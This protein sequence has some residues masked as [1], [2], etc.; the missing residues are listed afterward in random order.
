MIHK[1]LFPTLKDEKWGYVNFGEESFAY[2]SDRSCATIGCS[3][4]TSASA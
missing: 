4:S 3:A 2:K 1:L